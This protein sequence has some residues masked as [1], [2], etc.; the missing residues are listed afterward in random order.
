MK[1][2][3]W[4]IQVTDTYIMV[5]LVA[6]KTGA[7]E[8]LK[9]NSYP[10]EEGVVVLGKILNKAKF[11]EKLKTARK[12]NKISGRL[13]LT[14]SGSL[15]LTKGIET[16]RL[17]KAEFVQYIKNEFSNF[18]VYTKKAFF[19]DYREFSLTEE[20]KFNYVV[21]LTE[22]TCSEYLK[23]FKQAGLKLAFITDATEALFEAL[24]FITRA[25]ELEAFQAAAPYGLVVISE[26][27]TKV[28]IFDK[29]NMLAHNSIDMG[30]NTI[31]EEG[32]AIFMAR[33]NSVLA[34]V[35]DRPVGVKD[36]LIVL[37]RETGADLLEK[38]AAA[39]DKKVYYAKKNNSFARLIALSSAVNL[40]ENK[41]P[42]NILKRHY[43][44]K[45]SN[46]SRTISLVLAFFLFNAMFAFTFAPTLQEIKNLKLLTTSA[47]ADIATEKGLLTTLTTEAKTLASVTA[48]NTYFESIK[49]L[50][51]KSFDDLKIAAIYAAISPGVTVNSLS[52]NEKL[53][54]VEGGTTDYSKISITLGA[55]VK[56]AL[57][58]SGKI[59]NISRASAKAFLFT[60]NFY[61]K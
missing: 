3:I 46:T 1:Q 20:R 31:D 24:P 39:T 8:I 11:L 17:K 59:V 7:Y 50:K 15:V 56:E 22:E 16:P 54:V 14:I 34:S 52:I 44:N 29:A 38:L 28:S 12:E 2:Q 45:L 48:E 37:E 10:L 36:L 21:S 25:T 19:F 30:L 35:K 58:S 60:L 41:R 47:N 51:T 13:V 61:L 43:E 53:L 5:V 23:S 6:K 27:V 33:I 9:S 40:L 26:E 49:A 42:L 4:A 55:L 18:A 32:T 57:I